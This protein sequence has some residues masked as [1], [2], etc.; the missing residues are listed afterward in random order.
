M[1]ATSNN[2]NNNSNTTSDNKM[3]NKLSEHDNNNDSSINDKEQTTSE[4]DYDKY[5]QF[6]DELFSFSLGESAFDYAER[7]FQKTP[8][9]PQVMALLGQTAAL[10]DKKKNKVFRDHWCDRLDLLQR[11]VDV[12][13]KCIKEHPQYG[14]CYRSYVMCATR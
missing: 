11:G 10:Y 12:S 14:P 3:K 4:C 7:L 13:R 1:N 2:N 9:R 5:I 8:D 6:R